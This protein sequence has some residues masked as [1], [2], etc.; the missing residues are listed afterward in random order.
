MKTTTFIAIAPRGMAD[1]LAAEIRAMGAADVREMRAG[2]EF[3]GDI[4]AAY[5]VC[6]W[7]RLANRVL[8]PLARFPADSADAL[9]EGVRRIN[10]E[11]H[12]S[13]AETLAVDANVSGSEV[14]HSHY[15]AL[16]IK[17]AIVDSFMATQGERPSV[18]TTNPNI[19]INCYLLRDTAD[20]YLDLSGS[21]LHQ[22]GYRLGTGAAPLKEN[23]AA[24][25]L[26]RAGWPEIAAKGGAFVDLMCGSGTLPLEA[27]MLAADM[28][29]GLYRRHYGFLRWKQ[30]N[31]AVWER[32]TGEAVYRREKGIES[33]PP[34][35]GFDSDRRVLDQARQNA[36]RLGLEDNIS[37]AYQD[38][39]DFRHDFPAAGLM[40]TNPPY[41]KR[42][43]EAGELPLLYQALGDVMKHNLRGWKAAV[44]TEDQSLGKELGLRATRLHTLYNGAIACKLIHFDI[45]PSTF[46][47][48]GRLPAVLAPEELSPQ[49][50]MF[51]NRLEKNL[52]Q[53]RK[54]TEREQVSCY[55]AYDA[56]L[57]DYA[58]AIDLYH[59]EETLFVVV[60]EYEAPREIDPAKSK[61]RLQEML[62]I[63]RS[64]LQVDENHLIL[65]VRSRQRGES[66]YR[67]LGTEE[68]F[69]VVREGACQL[70][71]NFEDYL[72]TGLFLDHRPLRL[73]LY[74]E[75]KD[76]SFLNLFAYTCTATVQAAAGGALR[77]TSVDMSRTY[78]DWGRHNM[79]QNGFTG[80]NHAFIQA[81]CIGWLESQRDLSYDIIMLDPPTFSN[82]KRMDSALDVQRDHG[83]LIE[84]AMRLLNPGGKLYFS[85]NLRT[86]SLST[87]V[88]EQFAV[89]DMTKQTIPPD[90]QRR[91]NIHRCWLITAST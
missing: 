11:A 2:V 22:R 87:R 15:A 39:Q 41:G 40:V 44:F 64:H 51:G 45:D 75:A 49:A 62:T 34:I 57:P 7:S 33:L 85:T 84:G 12:L 30:H 37:F 63:V 58:A 68:R 71:V 60:Q 27:A 35:L 79:A 3:A 80:P 83:N 89:R 52:R 86:F 42:I 21:S 25:I 82:S 20:I 32:L 9:Y 67:K 74:R 91:Q 43:G 77:T 4:E 70:R 55:R 1:L 19:R 26:I 29:P 56:D 61:W 38:I 72:D 24:A 31:P 28:A 53:L 50:Q 65:K 17:D 13:P 5:R 23:L 14:T 90:F 8:L 66:Q 81:D 54:W 36:S 88:S 73:R 10:W 47:R 18:D 78:L 59:V 76:K 16:R 69:H 48:E 46:F 6:L